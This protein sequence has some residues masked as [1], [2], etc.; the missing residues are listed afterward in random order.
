MKNSITVRSKIGAFDKTINISGDKSLSIRWALLASIAI[1]KSRA[2]NLLD[3]D[4]VKSTLKILK[5]LGV[6]I[7]K[8]NKLVRAGAAIVCKG[9]F[10]NL[11]TSFL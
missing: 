1:G 9:I 5:K 6:N 10:V 11:W 7:I 3:S 8:N 4:D 2:F